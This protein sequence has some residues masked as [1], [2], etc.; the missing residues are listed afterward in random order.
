VAKREQIPSMVIQLISEKGPGRGRKGGK[1]PGDWRKKKGRGTR[2]YPGQR[3]KGGA[4]ETYHPGKIKSKEVDS[5]P[6]LK[7]KEGSGHLRREKM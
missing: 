3:K 4:L 1:I 7:G 6:V 5:N 2:L